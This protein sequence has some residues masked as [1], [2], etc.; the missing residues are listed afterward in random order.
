MK[1]LMPL[2]EKEVKDLLRDPR[3]YIGLIIPIIMLPITGI[4]IS[5][6]IRSVAEASVKR[7]DVAVIDQDGSIL[8]RGYISMLRSM[9]LNIINPESNSLNITIREAEEN[10]LKAVIIIRKGFG[11]QLSNFRRVNVDV[12]LIVGGVGFGSI[13]G[14]SALD[15]IIKLSS[16][17]L[18]SA[19]ISKIAPNVNPEDVRNPLNIT[20]YTVIKGRIISAAP[21]SIMSQLV[22]G[23]GVI[24]PLVL[25]ILALTMAQIAATATAVENEEKTLETLLTFPVSRY[26]ILLA[27]LLGSSVVA[28]L[29]GIIF[30]VGFFLYIGGLSGAFIPA[31]TF[32][33][34]ELN[35]GVTNVL[36]AIPPPP[37]ESYFIL[38]V[39]LIISILFVTSTGIVI[40]ALS[41]DVRMASS[42]LGVIVIPIFIPSIIIMY[43]DPRVL[44]VSLQILV[45]AFPTSYP[46]ILAKEMFLSGVPQEVIYGIPYSAALT[47]AVIYMTSKILAPEKLLVLQ[48]RLK[49][50]RIRRGKKP[51]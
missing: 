28:V 35:V 26:E 27:K 46:M 8:S 5:S 40:G 18:S 10:G 45:Y 49:M 36:S 19:L 17:A 29:G 50:R 16:K 21:Q 37:S 33:P 39:S 6:S 12:Y 34:I 22:I 31:G 2:I 43:G 51:S 9:G 38:A 1:K 4:I 41:S 11:E 14:F 48:H 13:G 47:F 32:I 7:L 30:A 42:L 44:P 15:E 20:R 23:Y 24:V 3:I 25:F